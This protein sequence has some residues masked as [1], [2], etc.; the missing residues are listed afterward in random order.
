[1][2]ALGGKGFWAIA[3]VAILIV[4][5]LSTWL[6]SRRS[7]AAS[8]EAPGFSPDRIAVMYFDSRGGQDSIGYLADGLTEAL[9][10]ELSEVKPLQVISR[11]GVAP[12]RNAAVAPDSIGRALKVGTSGS[13]KCRRLR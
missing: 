4:L 5:G 3:T 2:P 7:G 13:G 6:V 1:M 10:H 12:Y 11:G 8:G 9:I